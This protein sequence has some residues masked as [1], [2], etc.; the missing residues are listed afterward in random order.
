MST[1]QSSDLTSQL[2][3][4]KGIDINKVVTLLELASTSSDA[5]STALLTLAQL[6]GP[7]NPHTPHNLTIHHPAITF[8]DYLNKNKT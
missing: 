2:V 1:R 8:F 3:V 6:Q 5:A 7:V 4:I